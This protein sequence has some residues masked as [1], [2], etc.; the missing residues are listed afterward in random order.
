M[1]L[2]QFKELRRKNLEY[3]M[4][5]DDLEDALKEALNKLD[6]FQMALRDSP[7]DLTS[8]ASCGRPVI[9]L[10]DGMPSCN[11]CDGTESKDDEDQDEN[12]EDGRLRA[13]C[14]GLEVQNIETLLAKGKT[15]DFRQI[16]QEIAK[17]AKNK[18]RRRNDGT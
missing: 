14:E 4:E 3:T 18:I 2:K 10:P 17:W 1:S 16:G 12:G 8:C 5:R 11:H 6:I 9:A 15:E 13:L 7:F